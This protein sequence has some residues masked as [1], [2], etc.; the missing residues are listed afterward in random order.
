M[1]TYNEFEAP[2]L[3]RIGQACGKFTIHSCGT[4]ERMLESVMN[5]SNVMLVEFQ[6]KE[7]DLVKV[8]SITNGRLP[9]KVNRSKD[10]DERYVW[11][12]SELFYRYVMDTL[13]VAI[14]L[15]MDIPADDSSVFLD[16]LKTNSNFSSSFK[17]MK[18]EGI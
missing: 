15:E 18:W 4:W 1:E 14:P 9:L 3:K 10:L 17:R 8:W 12:S 16:A 7:M 11:D 5:D 2:Y 13:P 6:C